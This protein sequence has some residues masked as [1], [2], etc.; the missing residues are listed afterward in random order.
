MTAYRK[1]MEQITLD[2]DALR[3]KAAQM[4][5]AFQ[6]AQKPHIR[7]RRRMLTVSAAAA[8]VLVFG[9]V[10]A[11]AV[12]GWDY[13]SIFSRYFSAQ[14]G[15]TVDYDFTGMGLDLGDVIEG[16]GFTLTFD[17]LLADNRYVYLAYH[18]TGD[19]PLLP[20]HSGSTNGFISNEMQMDITLLKPQDYDY[21]FR[22]IDRACSDNA[23]C[24]EN[25]VYHGLSYVRLASPDISLA[26]KQ[27]TVTVAGETRSYPLAGI[28]VREGIC[29]PY[30]GTLPNDANENTFD[31]L[32]LTPFS[33]EFTKTAYSSYEDRPIW[34]YTYGDDIVPVNITAVY[35][36]GSEKSLKLMNSGYDVSAHSAYQAG[37]NNAYTTELEKRYCLASPL[38]MDGLTAIRINGTEIPVK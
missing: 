12:N 23:D 1:M 25:G 9:T 22:F 18:Y 35:A 34:Q 3:E 32:K 20:G 33:M 37:S 38:R 16:D 2:D 31:T 28:T 29:V 10:T 26:D 14:S 15:E 36:D 17:A 11:G 24:D 5:N 27:L 30:G 8:A 7:H 13:K 4:R 6:Q 19:A 21:S